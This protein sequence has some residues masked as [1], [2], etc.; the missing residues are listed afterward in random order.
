[1]EETEEADRVCIIDQGRV[2]ADGS[3]ADLRAK[4]SSSLLTLTTAT[5][6]EQRTVADAQEARRVLSELGDAVLDF[7][8]RHGRMDDVFIALTGRSVSEVDA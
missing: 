5:G 4:H 8:F 7:E 1:M 2:I 6:T 3:P